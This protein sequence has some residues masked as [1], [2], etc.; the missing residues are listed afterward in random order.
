MRLLSQKLFSQDRIE[1]VKRVMEDKDY[2]DQL[3]KEFGI[4]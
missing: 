1:D 4:C 2:C 3:K